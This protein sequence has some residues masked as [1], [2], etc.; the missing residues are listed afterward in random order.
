MS[1]LRQIKTT[2]PLERLYRAHIEPHHWRGVER[3]AYIEAFGER[4]ALDLIAAVIGVIERRPPDEV[5]ERLYNCKSARECIEEGLS[6]D[7]ELRLF[8]TGS[9][10]E[11]LSYV[12]EPLFLVEAPSRLA[13]VWSR[14]ML[15][16]A[17]D[18]DV[19]TL[20]DAEVGVAWWNGLSRSERADWLVRA[21]SAVP[22]DAWAA[23][24]AAGRHRG[25][26]IAGAVPGHEVR[27]VA[28]FASV[29]R[30]LRETRALSQVDLAALAGLDVL[31]VQE[32]ED[33]QHDPRLRELIALARGLQVTP[34]EFLHLVVIIEAGEPG[35][36]RP[37]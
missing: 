35:Q 14:T 30:S 25:R 7:Q 27:S 17:H 1:N 21:K 16:A 31:T 3:T 33:A 34:G 12:R 26:S 20:T 36:E 18:G 4:D 22:A 15:Q 28:A 23:Y 2:L 24:K 37:T 9:G 10:P 5:R 29:L 11:G 19:P 32:M 8:E 6:E 13:R